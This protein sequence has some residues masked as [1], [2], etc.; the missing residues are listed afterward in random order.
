MK[1]RFEKRLNPSRNIQYLIP[2][3]SILVALGV[4]GL[5]MKLTGI[6]PLTAYKAMLVG[7][8]GSS[9]S[10]SETLV[11][12]TPLIL[13][14]LAICVAFRMR[15]W[16]I[17]V[18]GQIVVGGFFAG[19]VA[20]YLP[21][22]WE[23]I[24]GPLL[25]FAMFIAGFLGGALWGFIP[26][27]LRAY[28]GVN[29]ILTTLLMNYVAI[30][31]VQYVYVGPWRD[32]HGWGFPGSPQFVEKAYLPHFPGMRV[33]LGL[34]IGL[35]AAVII[36]FILSRTKWGYQIRIIGEN[37]KAAKYGG[38]NV[39]GSTILV[40]VISGGLAGIA[41]MSEVSGIMHRLMDGLS[42]GNGYSAIIVAYI[43]RLNPFASIL[44]SFLLAVLLVGGDQLQIT[45][46]LPASFALVLEGVILFLFLMGIIFENY[47]L[48]I[49]RPK[50]RS[51]LLASQSDSQS[52]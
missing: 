41:G 47:S 38:I 23:S 1:I 37:I 11:K 26:A 10:I 34:I 5:I 51:G 52:K 22:L 32:P 24:P 25:L 14:S 7:A 13:A 36:W 31:L 20:L 15:F 16:N 46:G 50:N 19:A 30:M 49:E 39:I 44:V 6:E 21:V 48:R 43:A 4:G 45:M 27:A 12:T 29:E 18:E 42:A 17:G 3:I 8:L 35:V 33:H 28:I 2:P 40:M 9:Y